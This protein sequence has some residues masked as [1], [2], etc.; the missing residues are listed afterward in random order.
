MP[1]AEVQFMTVR[2]GPN[3]SN[4]QGFQFV[5][6]HQSSTQFISTAEVAADVK[7]LLAVQGVD[8]LLTA[9]ENRTRASTQNGAIRHRR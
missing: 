7:S 3:R 2:L 8:I 5:P 1:S 4:L 9:D 6:I